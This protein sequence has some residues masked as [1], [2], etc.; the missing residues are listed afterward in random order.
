ML[1]GPP[2]RGGRHEEV[3]DAADVKDGGELS[4]GAGKALVVA[5]ED[6][7]EGYVGLKE[8]EPV[9]PGEDA[10]EHLDPA[11]AG[12]GAL[13]ARVGEAAKAEGAVDRHRIV[14][15]EAAAEALGVIVGD[16]VDHDEGPHLHREQRHVALL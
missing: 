5:E 11:K 16:L 4:C 1:R 10:V 7:G 3:N 2:G 15:A 14:D 6:E 8:P 12:E 13:E 9:R